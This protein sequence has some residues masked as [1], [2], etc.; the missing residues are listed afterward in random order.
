MLI[1]DWEGPSL[2]VR[3]RA[4]FS[5]PPGLRY[6]AVLRELEIL[7]YEIWCKLRSRPFRYPICE[8]KIGH[9]YLVTKGIP[10]VAFRVF[11]RIVTLLTD[12][13]LEQIHDPHCPAC[14]SERA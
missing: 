2:R 11:G 10:N 1:Q 4:A 9:R 3:I 14:R 13:A 5:L 6:T 7:A 12:V 8:A